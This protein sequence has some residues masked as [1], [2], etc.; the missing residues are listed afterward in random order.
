MRKYVSK[1]VS[2][3]YMDVFSIIDVSTVWTPEEI[4]KF[5]KGLLIHGRQWK[6]VAKV[7]GTRSNVACKNYV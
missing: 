4:E 5:C 7:I 3:K 1:G 2:H 6:L